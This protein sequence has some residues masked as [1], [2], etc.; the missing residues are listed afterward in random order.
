MVLALI[1]KLMLLSAILGG[2]LRDT[3]QREKLAVLFDFIYKLLL[4]I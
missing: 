3:G 4:S 1:G 2:K